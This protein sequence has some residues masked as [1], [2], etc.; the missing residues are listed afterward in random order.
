ME[1]NKLEYSVPGQFVVDDVERDLCDAF[2]ERHIP[3][4]RNLV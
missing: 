1:R 2:R 3:D 4:I